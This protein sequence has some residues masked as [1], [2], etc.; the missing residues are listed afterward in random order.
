MMVFVE[1]FGLLI[2]E[3]VKFFRGEVGWGSE[4]S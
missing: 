1:Y 4:L 3:V 2:T